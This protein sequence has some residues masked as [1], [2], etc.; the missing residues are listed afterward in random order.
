MKTSSYVAVVVLMTGLIASCQSSQ[1]P[2]TTV[3][4]ARSGFAMTYDDLRGRVVIYGGTDIESNRRNDTWEWNGNQWLQIDATGPPPLSDALFTFDKSNGV[5]VVF[6]GRSEDGLTNDTWLFDGTKWMLADTS[7]PEPR[8]LGAMAYDESSERIILYGGSGEER[9]RL[10]DTWAWDGESWSEL[11]T[12]DGP[13]GLGAHMMTFD[14]NL[15]TVVI[16]GGYD[17]SNT[18]AQTWAFTNNDWVLADS[19]TTPPRLHGSVARDVDENRLLLFGGFGEA[20]RD[21]TTWA[22]DGVAW[23]QLTTSTVP[24][25]AEHEAVFVPGS[26]LTVFGGVVGQDMAVTERV[27]SNTLKTL[28]DGVW[29]V[30]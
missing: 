8:Q 9:R 24:G 10:S 30:R 4:D 21:S 22:F 27:K 26:G 6:G 19:V 18:L 29:T 2:N 25:H 16:V 12:T 17:G 11:P 1:K 23:S 20:G 14:D 15:E 5:T 3:P 7:G 28:I 13:G